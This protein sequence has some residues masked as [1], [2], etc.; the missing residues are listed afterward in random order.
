MSAREGGR[1]R[2]GQMDVERKSWGKR[3]KRETWGWERGKENGRG[4]RETERS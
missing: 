2:E 1:G 4:G 3:G